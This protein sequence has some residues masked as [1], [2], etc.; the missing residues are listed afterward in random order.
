MPSRGTPGPFFLSDPEYV[1]DLLTSAG[2]T[3]VRLRGLNEPMYFG[4][5]VDD[6]CQFICGQFAWMIDD[7]DTR[8]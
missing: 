4:R 6:A 7:L 8:H 1:H 5:N 2:F 3:N